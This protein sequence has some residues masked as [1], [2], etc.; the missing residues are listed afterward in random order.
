MERSFKLKIF[1]DVGWIPPEPELLN[2]DRAKEVPT[3]GR[4]V[5]SLAVAGENAV[6]RPVTVVWPQ[7][8]SQIASKVNDCY[9]QTLAPEQA[10]SEL[11]STLQDIEDNV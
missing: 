9:S 5:D 4:Y 2:S 1:E 7:Q 6:P 8:S 3:I 10:M 11:K